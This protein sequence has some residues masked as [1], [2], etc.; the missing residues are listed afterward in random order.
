MILF[1][2]S[3]KPEPGKPNI[4]SSIPLRHHISL[5]QI[6]H[7]TLLRDLQMIWSRTVTSAEDENRRRKKEDRWRNE[8]TKEE[9]GVGEMNECDF[10]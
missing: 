6:N 4:T 3:S 1:P 2:S 8:G 7:I 5:Q 10:E 9:I